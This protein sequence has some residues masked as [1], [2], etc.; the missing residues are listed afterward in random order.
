MAVSSTGPSDS[1][2]QSKTASQIACL[3]GKWRKRAPCV[4]PIRSAMAWV[5]MPSGLRSRARAT[6]A[7][8]ISRWR[9]SVC[10]RSD[11]AGGRE[12]FARSRSGLFLVSN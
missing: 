8:T 11:R 1:R 10:K 3:S 12:R 6:T 5:V 7:A 2:T 9:S 4:T